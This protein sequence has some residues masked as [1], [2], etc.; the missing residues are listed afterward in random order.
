VWHKN[1][2]QVRCYLFVSC[3]NISV[4][5]N[6][7]T[8]DTKPLTWNQF[9]WSLRNSLE[10][11]FVI[12]DCK[13]TRK[14]ARGVEVYLHSFLTSALYRDQWSTS[15]PSR[16]IP[17]KEPQS[18]LNTLMGW[19]HRQSGRFGGE[20]NVLPSPGSK[21]RIN[22]LV[23]Y[24]SAPRYYWLQL[25]EIRFGIRKFARFGYISQLDTKFKLERR[26]R[27]EV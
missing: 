3:N 10:R 14:H 19:S 27:R 23:A 12:S 20:I 22:Q 9:L 25:K 1:W 8:H 21:P 4:T 6:N 15:R 2:S 17:V 13:N 7:T 24:M 11:H 26:Y 5:R 18:S 16:F